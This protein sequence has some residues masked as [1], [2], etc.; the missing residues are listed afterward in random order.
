MNVFGILRGSAMR[1]KRSHEIA[2]IIIGLVS[3]LLI[4]CS[5]TSAVTKSE[6]AFSKPVDES[7][8][9]LNQG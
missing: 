1:I 3:L 7:E 6:S 4:G 8:K 9:F 5:S 2:L